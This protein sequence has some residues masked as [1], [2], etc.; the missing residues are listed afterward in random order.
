MQK[1]GWEELCLWISQIEGLTCYIILDELSQRVAYIGSVSLIVKVCIL[2]PPKCCLAGGSHGASHRLQIVNLD[3]W[4]SGRHAA[5]WKDLSKE[6][7]LFRELFSQGPE[8][9]HL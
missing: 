8:A 7:C 2:R 4:K 1:V 9:H 6:E 5:T 3:R